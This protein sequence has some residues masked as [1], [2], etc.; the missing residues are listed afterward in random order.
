MDRFSGRSP[1][2]GFVS[3]YDK[4]A[5]EEAIEAMNGM[6]LDGRSIT[7]DKAQPNQG[8]G[9]DWDWDGDRGRDHDRERTRDPM[10]GVDLVETASNVETRAFRSG[11]SLWRT[12]K[13]RW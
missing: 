3:F 2:L 13:R 10:V 1:G 6:D 7:V 11:M 4:K 12:A 5:M 8:S 9:R